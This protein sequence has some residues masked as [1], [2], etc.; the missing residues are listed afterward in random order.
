[1]IKSFF[2]RLALKIAGAIVLVAAAVALAWYAHGKIMR[3]DAEKKHALLEQEL[4]EVAELTL[5]K[6]RYS[7]IITIKKKLLAAKAY[8]IVRYTGTVRAGIADISAAE[9][10]ISAD[11]IRADVTLPRCEIIGN[12]IT[13]QSVFDKQR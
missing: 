9:I 3:V 1:M 13:S 12:D 7:D 5:C 4:Q 2:A 11:G 8:S 10:R 6:M